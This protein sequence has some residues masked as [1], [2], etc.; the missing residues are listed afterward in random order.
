M[1]RS[2]KIHRFSSFNIEKPC[3]T[4][5]VIK[6]ELFREIIGHG[7]EWTLILSVIDKC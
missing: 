4:A 6:I 3:S 7:F 2:A 5:L 1:V